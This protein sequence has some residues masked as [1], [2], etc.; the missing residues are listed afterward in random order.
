[1][2]RSIRR[3]VVAERFALRRRLVGE[4]SD[5]RDREKEEL[6]CPERVDCRSGGDST[7]K[8]YREAESLLST[9]GWSARCWRWRG[10]WWECGGADLDSEGGHVLLRTILR[11]IGWSSN[12]NWRTVLT[13]VSW[14]DFHLP[15]PPAHS[16]HF[17]SGLS[18]ATSVL[19]NNNSSL[20]VGCC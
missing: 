12:N 6:S 1:M 2:D 17:H 11:R 14:W 8:L 3:E 7:C 16:S 20:V 4:R 9:C 15:S 18:E 10:A 5:C 19:C 13:W